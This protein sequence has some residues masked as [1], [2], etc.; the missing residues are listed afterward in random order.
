MRVSVGGR[1]A[2]ES[3]R[4]GVGHVRARRRGAA[5]RRPGAARCAHGEVAR[6]VRVGGEPRA[7]SAR[8]DRR[9]DVELGRAAGPRRRRAGS[10]TSSPRCAPRGVPVIVSLW[11]R[12][13]DDFADA[14][15][16]LAPHADACAAIELN[17]SCPNV[18]DAS[19]MFAHSPDAT[20]AVVAAVR[21]GRARPAA[22]R[23]AVAEHVRGRRR[24][25]RRGRRG[26]RRPDAR[27]HAARAR[28]RRREPA[29]AARRR[30]RRATPARRSSR[31]RSGWCTR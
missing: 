24:R 14:A 13:V 20:R 30:H 31:W 12:S 10:P 21:G 22:V 9:R 16:L 11:G 29:P 28:D 3:D 7:A 6:R 15:R 25:A 27:E 17:V 8:R 2:R 4:R 18:E 23:Q 19:R 5:P 26:R 1:A